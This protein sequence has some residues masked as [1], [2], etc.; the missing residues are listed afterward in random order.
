MDAVAVEEPLEIRL[1]FQL[2]SSPVRRSIAVTMR[3][4]GHDAELAVGFLVGEGLLSKA[5]TVTDVRPCNDDPTVEGAQNVIRVDVENPNTEALSRLDRNFYTTSSC[6]VCGKASI[7]AIA[8]PVLHVDA[9]FTVDS[10]LIPGLP[11]RLRSAQTAFLATG[12][13]HGAGLFDEGGTLLL[14]REDVGRHNALDKIVGRLFLDG[15]LPASGRLLLLS[16]R[17]SFELIQK[18]LVAGIRFIAAVGA[19]STLAIDLAARHDATLVGFVRD[20]G[21]NIYSGA[22]RITAPR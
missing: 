12:G 21:Y 7:D 17:A 20:G 9:N 2:G 6:G 19:P 13:I 8:V 5:S 4:P 10:E 3:T 1:G 14:V 11:A 15:E 16:G 22:D 18:A